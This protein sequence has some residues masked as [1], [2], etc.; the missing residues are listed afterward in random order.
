MKKRLICLSLTAV[1]VTQLLAYTDANAIVTGEKNHYQSSSLKLN[2][3]ISDKTRAKLYRD[4]LE[5]LLYAL[6]YKNNIGYDEKEY[7]NL[8]EEY[9]NKVLAEIE[10]VNK[11]NLEQKEIDSLKQENK[12]LPKGVFGL[13]YSRYISVYESLKEN[14]AAFENKLKQIGEK[15]PDLKEFNYSQQE[16]ANKKINTL[17]N[18]I[19]LVGQA[20]YKQHSFE[21]NNLYNKLDLIVGFKREDRKIREPKN[22]RMLDTM[23]EDLDHIIN[24]FFADINKKRPDNIEPLTADENKN[25]KNIKKLLNDVEK[26]KGYSTKKASQIKVQNFVQKYDDVYEAMRKRAIEKINSKDSKLV[27]SLD[28]DEDSKKE[29][30]QKV[31]R[32]DNKVSKQ[33]IGLSNIEKEI[34]NTVKYEP[35]PQFNSNI[36]NA[37]NNITEYSNGSVKYGP[38]PKFNNNIVN[39]K[40]NITEYSNGSVK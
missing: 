40:N 36:V 33:V 34:N 20:F 22:K 4:S 35:D 32:K 9:S 19:L 11:F 8:Y 5:D 17:E 25:H 10:A 29:S 30:K 24:E 31:K 13:T 15:Y 28:Y 26:S 12:K 27:V 23:I 6:Q 21:T 7:K 14:K 37:K 18:K 16:D 1:C 2:G 3:E 38:R 39:A